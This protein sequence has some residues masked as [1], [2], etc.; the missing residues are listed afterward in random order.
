[1]RGLTGAC[2]TDVGGKEDVS[3]AVNVELIE[4]I[5][6]KVQLETSVEIFDASFKLVPVESCD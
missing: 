5:L 6:S 2:C 4:I 3:E 1:M